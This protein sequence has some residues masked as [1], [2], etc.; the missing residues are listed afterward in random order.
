MAKLSER[1]ELMVVFNTK[2]GEDG[3]KALVE[4]FKNYLETTATFENIEE[5]G[6]RKLA[7]AIE[8][9]TEGYYVLMHFEASTNVPAELTRR[10]NITDGV[11][12]SLVTVA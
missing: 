6:K 1:Y 9:E 2:L 8:D 12:R 11:L 3:I 4:K 7:Y 5:W 10:L